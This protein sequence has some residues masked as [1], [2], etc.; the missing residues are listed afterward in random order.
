MR[1]QL[2]NRPSPASVSDTP[3][4]ERF[5]SE[6]PRAFSSSLTCL[7]NADGVVWSW[8]AALVKLAHSAT[9]TNVFSLFRSLTASVE[10]ILR[11]DV[12]V[13]GPYRSWKNDFSVKEGTK[14]QEFLLACRELPQLVV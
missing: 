11:L 5:S 3:W 12:L 10:D 4:V 13:A 7:L 14:H 6:N 9:R 1:R 8:R 2:F